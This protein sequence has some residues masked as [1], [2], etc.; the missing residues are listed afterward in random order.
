MQSEREKVLEN[1]TVIALK[2]YVKDDWYGK[3]Y[4]VIFT[5][6]YT[7]G[8][9]NAKHYKPYKSMIVRYM[10][11]IAKLTNDKKRTIKDIKTGPMSSYPS[12]TY[13]SM[14]PSYSCDFTFIDIE[15]LVKWDKENPAIKLKDMG[16]DEKRELRKERKAEKERKEN[17]SNRYRSS[18][19]Y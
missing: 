2:W 7:T 5:P 12:Y 15:G 17:E 13:C 14:G 10:N 3:N 6:T 1:C 8:W 16:Y 19:Y 9:K 18:V 4:A 11:T